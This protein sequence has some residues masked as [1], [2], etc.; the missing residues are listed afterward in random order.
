M[1]NK[2]NHLSTF[3]R[4][5]P[6]G[7]RQAD[8]HRGVSRLLDASPVQLWRCLDEARRADLYRRFFRLNWDE[9][10]D[11]LEN[12]EASARSPQNHAALGGAIWS[13]WRAWRNAAVNRMAMGGQIQGDEQMEIP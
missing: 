13:L 5:L 3:S 7:C 8:L 4:S 10:C 9:L 12:H 1:K 2:Q 11:L 6:P